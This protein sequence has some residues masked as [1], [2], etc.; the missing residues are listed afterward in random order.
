M[1]AKTVK[2]KNNEKINDLANFLKVIAVKNRFRILLLLKSREMSVC[3]ISQ[4]LNLAQNLVSHHLKA[5]KDLDL[6]RCHRVGVKIF[7]RLNRRRFNRYG[8][9][10]KNFL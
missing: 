3:K 5:L 2:E 1:K 7:Y 6:I 8:K 9:L 4:A 10:L